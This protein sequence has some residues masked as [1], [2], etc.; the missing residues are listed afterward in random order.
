MKNNKLFEKVEGFN[1]WMKTKV[2][3]VY[4]SDNKRMNDA[5]ER[6]TIYEPYKIKQ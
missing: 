6:L 1:H 3:S 5:F 2:Q 4:Y